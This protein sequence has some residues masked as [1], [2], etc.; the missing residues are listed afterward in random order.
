ML[1]ILK[2]DAKF[3]G[4]C[5][6]IDYSLLLGEIEDDPAELE[7]AILLNPKLGH[8]VFWDE[9]GRP[10]IVGIIDPLTGFK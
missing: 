1:E 6:I 5:S 3:L 10:Y 9:T 8:G 7:E 4:R 2:D